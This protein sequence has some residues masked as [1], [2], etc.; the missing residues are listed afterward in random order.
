LFHKSDVNIW[1]LF[2]NEEMSIDFHFK[3]WSIFQVC[4]LSFD[5]WSFLYYSWGRIHFVLGRLVL[6]LDTCPYA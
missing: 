2:D 3:K 5:G 4:L 6:I 1:C